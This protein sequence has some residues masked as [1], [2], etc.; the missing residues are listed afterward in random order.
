MTGHLPVMLAEVL[1][2]LEPR[3]GAHYIDGTFGGGGYARAILEACDCRVLGID[4]DPDAIARG[5]ALVALYPGRLTLVHGEFSQMDRLLADSGEDGTNGVVLDLGVSS[6]Q[7]DEPARGFSFRADGPLDMR[8][9]LS[10]LS[11]ADV[12]NTADE[13]TLADII[14]RYG[15]ERQARRIAR[16]VVADRPFTR[17][18]ELAELVARVLG[19]AAARQPIHP[20]T[21]TFQAL[22]IYVNDELGELA[23]ALEA[24]T[25]VLKPQGRLAVVSFHSLEDRI[26]KRFLSERS[27]SAP[28][29]S[30][31]APDT[32]RAHVPD[33][34]LLGNRP[35]GPGDAEIANNPRARSAKLR[36]AERLAA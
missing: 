7:F 28:R 6:F 31:H 3:D 4:R 32:R 29:G 35:L 24:A 15:E 33:Y 22:R 17:T 12:V 5:Q 26:V 2:A 11:A 20:A 30:R 36:V 25:R 1:E 23:R 19:P 10:G 21:R 13:K 8:M 27:A 14:A 9:S 18:A 16:A 34:R